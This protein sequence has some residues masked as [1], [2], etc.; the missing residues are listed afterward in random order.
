[1]LS[2]GN[3]QANVKSAVLSAWKERWPIKKW[4]IMARKALQSGNSIDMQ[5]M[6]EILFSQAFVGSSPNTVLL[7]YF[8]YSLHTNIFTY[9]AVLAAISRHEDLQNIDSK[10]CILK[11]LD[12]CIKDLNSGQILE[13][14]MS[15]CR[16]LLSLLKWL[17]RNIEQYLKGVKDVS[18]QHCD[19][20]VGISCKTLQSLTQLTRTSSLLTVARFEESSVWSHIETDLAVIRNAAGQHN[21]QSEVS[22]TCLCVSQLSRLHVTKTESVFDFA[23]SGTSDSVIEIAVSVLVLME[24]DPE[25]STDIESMS[26]NFL[27]IVKLCNLSISKLIVDIIRTCMIAYLDSCGSKYEQKWMTILFVSLPQYLL[28]LK[29]NLSMLGD[30]NL[31]AKLK[32]TDF[33]KALVT[34]MKKLITFDGLLNAIDVKNNRSSNCCEI[35]MQQFEEFGLTS[36]A[37]LNDVISQRM[38]QWNDLKDYGCNGSS[39]MEPLNAIKAKGTTR[40]L[41]KTLDAGLYPSNKDDLLEM[42]D[43]ICK[44]MSLFSSTA[45]SSGCI[46]EFVK[47]VIS[48]ND[49]VRS[50]T[51]ESSAGALSRS[52][53]FELTFLMICHIAKENGR[54][55]ILNAAWF[56]SNTEIPF[57]YNWIKSYWPE[58]KYVTDSQNK[59]IKAINLTTDCNRVERLLSLIRQ[60]TEVN[61]G[62]LK[63]WDDL[64]T[65]VPEAMYEI[66]KAWQFGVITEQAVIRACEA[67]NTGVSLSVCLC[68]VTFL[69]NK[70][71]EVPKL[72]LKSFYKPVID[73]L[74]SKTK[75]TLSTDKKYCQRHKMFENIGRFLVTKYL[76]NYFND[77]KMESRNIKIPLAEKLKNL[78]ESSCQKKWI[79]F[80]DLQEYNKLLHLAGPKWFCRQLLTNILSQTRKDMVRQTCSVVFSLFQLDIE[81]L[82]VCLLCNELPHFLTN[83]EDHLMLSE[84]AGTALAQMSVAC[85]AIVLQNLSNQEKVGQVNMS[86][87]KTLQKI[88]VCKN[89]DNIFIHQ[90]NSV[91]ERRPTKLQRLMSS[92][93]EH[94]LASSDFSSLLGQDEPNLKQSS[95][96]EPIL[97]ALNYCLDIMHSSLMERRPGPHTNFILQ[98]INLSSHA[99]EFVPQSV[100]HLMQ[101]SMVSELTTVL[102]SSNQVKFNANLNDE[103][104]SIQFT[105]AISDLGDSKGRKIAAKSICQISL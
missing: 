82:T 4:T 8:H 13:D 77:F 104:N 50:C 42:F 96:Q 49:V 95:K 83:E 94:D 103:F 90:E 25:R 80:N 67:V 40:S 14:C 70:A 17:L 44:S 2:V 37:S 31:E 92:T 85:L 62:Q 27:M 66:V 88:M 36:E 15:L 30:D 52:L 51:A 69:A 93:T 43:K 3:F 61:N 16:S 72:A 39:V 100:L 24:N 57:M 47:R 19:E 65:N 41:L 32:E 5:H 105:L 53:L 79:S 29:S 89:S 23:S 12:I 10:K 9:G 81:S 26:L 56:G 84:P 1:M 87:K 63:K 78:I 91:E 35:L 64:C 58:E 86:L 48:I 102:T 6:A 54:N 11:L 7:N 22:R 74:L 33:E 38:R 99:G 59:N 68:S 71:T 98:F 55:V 34:A 46:K 28:S 97:Q 20:I 21:L 101:I 18:V 75:S 45:K 73:K 60:G 76:P